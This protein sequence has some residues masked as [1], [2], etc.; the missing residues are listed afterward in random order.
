MATR[1]LSHA[2]IGV[3][4][5]D[6]SVAFSRDVAGLEVTFDDTEELRD[7]DGAVVLRRRVDQRV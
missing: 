2:A 6:M 1:N 3:R 7:A 4:D 5:V